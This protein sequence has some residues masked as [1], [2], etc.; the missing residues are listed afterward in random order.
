MIRSGTIATV[1]LLVCAAC[2]CR[3]IS[4][5]ARSHDA[6]GTMHA[7]IACANGNFKLYPYCREAARDIVPSASIIPELL[8]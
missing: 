4:L 6:A 7:C 3:T 1:L 5:R 8:E 2:N